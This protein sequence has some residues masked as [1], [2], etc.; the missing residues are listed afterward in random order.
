MTCWPA[1]L[2]L[3][4]KGETEPL[5]V[6]RVFVKLSVPE[7]MDAALQGLTREVLRHQPGDIYSFAAQYFE[8]LVRARDGRGGARGGARGRGRPGKS[9]HL[10]QDRGPGEAWR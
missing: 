1:L 9:W 4:A 5:R 2:V 7:G 8:S 3:E 6:R 10:P